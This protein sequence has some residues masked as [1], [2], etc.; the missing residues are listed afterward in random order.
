MVGRYF[1]LGFVFCRTRCL[2]G[3]EAGYDYATGY[4]E[5]HVFDVEEGSET[6]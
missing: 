2:L 4:E 1:C 5:K 6:L 3:I